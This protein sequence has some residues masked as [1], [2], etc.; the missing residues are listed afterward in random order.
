MVFHC[1]GLQNT[2]L[3]LVGTKPHPKIPQK[4]LSDVVEI[5]QTIYVDGKKSALNDNPLQWFV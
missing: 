1:H 2:Y 5:I 3:S 4:T